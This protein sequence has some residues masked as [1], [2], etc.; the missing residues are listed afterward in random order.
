VQLST[1]SCTS[2][3]S[4]GMH[5]P[6]IGVHVPRLVHTRDGLPWKP[7]TQVPKTSMS[8]DVAVVASVSGHCAYSSSLA[9]HVRR[10]QAWATSVSHVP[11]MKHWRCGWPPSLTRKP[12]VQLPD[13]DRPGNVLGHVASR[14]VPAAQ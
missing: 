2:S 5:A 8:P 13:P 3:H 6:E 12:T 14:Y 4:I 11:F 7:S 9:S 1:Q 10:T